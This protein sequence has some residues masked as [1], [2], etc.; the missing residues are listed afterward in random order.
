VCRAVAGRALSAKLRAVLDRAPSPD[1]ADR[2]D[3]MAQFRTALTAVATPEPMPVPPPTPPPA[4]GTP[5]VPP[6]V[7][8]VTR[9]FGPG[10]ARPVGSHHRTGPQRRARPLRAA[11]IV[12]GA[13]ALLGGGVAAC[14]RSGSAPTA[15]AAAGP[16]CAD[17]AR[18]PTGQGEVLVGDVDGDGCDDEVNRAGT[19]ITV[20]LPAGRVA[21]RLGQPGDTILLGDWDCD[22][23]DTPALYRPA[24]GELR[25]YD[26]WPGVTDSAGSPAS[27]V[28]AAEPGGHAVK[29]EQVGRCD[30]VMVTPAS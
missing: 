21:F 16:A 8:R 27:A 25:Y 23:I 2:F 26:A 13:S 1:V 12:A 18:H 20:P 7:Q 9:R 15:I 19:V 28:R 6:R 17:E 10:P 29:R 14:V 4:P 11:A 22:G 24:S 30:D 3:G 5:S